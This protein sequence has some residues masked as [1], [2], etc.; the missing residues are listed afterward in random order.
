[1][2]RDFVEAVVVSVWH[3]VD[4]ARRSAFGAEHGSADAAPWPIRRELIKFQVELLMLAPHA[5]DMGRA[6]SV[7]HPGGR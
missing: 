5:A 2:K 3:D 1:M 4:A 7:L 6:V